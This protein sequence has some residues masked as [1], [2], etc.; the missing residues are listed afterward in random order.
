MEDYMTPVSELPSQK[1]IIAYVLM[2]FDV[3]IVLQIANSFT[4]FSAIFFIFGVR[5]FH[6]R[7]RK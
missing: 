1:L 4:S 5:D 2:C 3:V 6:P 7:R